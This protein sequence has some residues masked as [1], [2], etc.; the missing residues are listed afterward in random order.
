M[1]PGDGQVSWQA[2]SVCLCTYNGGRYLR[3]LL[4]SLAAQ[5]LLPAELLVGDDGSSDDT[6][7]IL[8]D[9]VAD[10]PFPVEVLANERRLGPACN[11]ER[12]LVRATGNTL[13]PCDQDDIWTPRKIEVLAA[14]LDESP[15]SG[16]AICNSS[17]IDS[18]GQFLPGSLFER[19]GLDLP[20]R[21]V[22]ASGSSAAMV[23]IARRNVVASHALAIRRSALD[24]VLPFGSYWQA[25]W[26]IAIVLSAITGIAIVEDR[27]VEYRLHDLNTV[28]LREKRPLAERAAHEG[29][30][31]FYSRA[32]LLGAALARVGELRPGIPGPADRAILEAQIAHLRA[33]GSLPAGRGRRVFPVLREALGGGYRRFSNGWRSVLGDVVRLSD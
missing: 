11:L 15:G 24:L 22:L 6:L 32:D 20:T 4:H 21:E 27:L 26:W 12:L 30:F 14:A 31:R 8:R 9:F 13:F 33:R 10:A 7:K 18:E 5:T 19:A 16:A 29:I 25:D 2:T 17:L 1:D 28:G 3:D 23:E